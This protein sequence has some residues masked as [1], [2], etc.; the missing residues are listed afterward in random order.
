VSRKNIQDLINR[1]PEANFRAIGQVFDRDRG[2]LQGSIEFYDRIIEKYS[3]YLNIP[4][5]SIPTTRS[6]KFLSFYDMLHSIKNDK[7]EK[8]KI[9]FH[10]LIFYYNLSVTHKQSFSDC[11]IKSWLFDID[12]Y[13]QMDDI[14]ALKFS[15][16]QP[17]KKVI[18]KADIRCW[19]LSSHRIC[20]TS[21]FCPK[22]DSTKSN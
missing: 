14:I 18:I 10:F 17:L 16:S 2:Y 15:Y 11:G 1:L 12:S 22:C 9:T 7:T 20:F 5:S 21:Q 19:F 6:P 13:K 3:E 8:I 4:I